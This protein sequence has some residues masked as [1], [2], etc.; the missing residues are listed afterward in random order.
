MRVPATSQCLRQAVHRVPPQR[1]WFTCDRLIQE[2][3]VVLLRQRGDKRAKWKLTPALRNEESHRVKLSYGA[4]V[5]A[6]DLI[7][8]RYLDTVTDSDGREVAIHEAS[9][10]SYIVNS[11]RMATPIYPQD[12]SVIVS[13]L[14]LNPERPGENDGPDDEVFEVFEAGTGM[15]SLTMHI[16]RALH[17]A[18]PPM[19]KDLRDAVATASLERRAPAPGGEA[20][21]DAEIETSGPEQLAEPVPR[22]ENEVSPSTD[23]GLATPEPPS[24]VP[25]DVESKPAPPPADQQTPIQTMTL[26]RLEVAPSIASDLAQW[27]SS[28]RAVLHTLDRNP[29]HARAAYKLLRRFRRAIYLPD[30]DF[31]IGSIHDYLTPRLASSLGAPFLSRAVLDLPSPE[32]FADPVVRALKPNG[33]LVVFNPSIS[34]IADFAKWA[35]TT[36]Q[37][38]RLERTAELPNTFHVAADEPT[39]NDCGG[40][41]PW[42]VRTVVPRNDASGGEIVQ[43]M[44]PRVGDRVLGGGFVAV[45]RRLKPR[46]E[47]EKEDVKE[48]EKVEEE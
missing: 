7:G 35:V 41:R 3:D 43:V 28:R 45:F 8:K 31:H 25:S 1:R 14:D 15:G 46:G 22:D 20:V 11:E 4:H 39:A 27:S 13:M 5:R 2:H 26:S 42:D 36:R 19:R 44:R 38:L 6:Q 23:S 21:A 9:M 33:L 30:V 48:E 37:P 16:A 12:C 29:A 17:A 24:P 18:N 47:V 10:A 34:Q 32:S 40:G